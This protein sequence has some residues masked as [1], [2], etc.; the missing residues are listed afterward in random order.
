MSEKTDVVVIGGG[1]TGVGIARDLSLRGK[2][3]VLVERNG[4]ADGTSG[5][6]HG[7]LHSGAR[8]AESDPRGAEECIEENEVIRDIAG[9]CIEDTGG[10]FLKLES[11]D[12]AYF[13]EK[14]EACEEIGIPTTVLDGEEVTNTYGE[15]TEAVDKAL[16]VPDAAIYPS[17]I[18]AATAES[19]A[20]NG[21]SIYTHTEVTDIIIEDGEAKGITCDGEVDEVHAEYVVNSTGAWAE[22][23]SESAGL[24]VP[25]KPTKGVMVSVEYPE[26]D[27]VVN[28]C[29]ETDDG[30]IAIPHQDEV[31]LGTTSVEVED[32]DEY[33]KKDWEVDLMYEECSEM[34]PGISDAEL[35]RTYWGVR[36][37]YA[38][39]ELERDSDD[40]NTG[41]GRSISRGF[42]LLDHSSDGVDQMC[43][44]VG[45]KLT[46]HRLMAEETVDF[47]ADELG[48]DGECRTA[49]TS[50]PGS[51]D[52]SAVD[53]FV[54]KYDAFS[55]ADRDVVE[56]SPAE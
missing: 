36:P 19:A 50:L 47:L 55:P 42:Q 26:L 15:V 5:R 25:M 40:S 17:R 35:T 28:R 8:Y 29:R 13:Q 44:V 37:L 49:S 33:P 12:D 51:D 34:V 7:L 9:S 11:D 4:L 18:V 46:T 10:L 16:T 52:P 23:V 31:V 45:G 22:E 41:S 38:P 56:K 39:D 24:D 48:F 6:S 30:D 53:E 14:R 54:G 3:V 20:E 43:S 32:P 21:A 27:V 2:D 1:A